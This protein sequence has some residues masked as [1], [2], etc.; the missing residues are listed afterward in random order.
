M[1]NYLQTQMTIIN[2]IKVI[3]HVLYILHNHNKML[4]FQYMY[5]NI[6]NAR[7]FFLFFKNTYVHARGNIQYTLYIIHYTL[8]IIYYTLYII[9]YAL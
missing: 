7:Y 5:N 4:L 3:Q 8:Y 6:C 9:H 2:S 1:L